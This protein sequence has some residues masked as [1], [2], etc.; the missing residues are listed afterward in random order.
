MNFVILLYAIGFSNYLIG[1]D[2]KKD[3]NKLIGL[4]TILI[5]MIMNACKA[6]I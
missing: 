2:T 6:V 5:A 3:L 4:I 1:M